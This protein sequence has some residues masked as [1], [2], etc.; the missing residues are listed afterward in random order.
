VRTVLFGS[1]VRVMLTVVAPVSRLGAANPMLAG[2]SRGALENEKGRE[3]DVC[4]CVV[5]PRL[6]VA[7][8]RS[9][10]NEKA[11]GP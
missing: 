2:P 6:R 9:R 7:A 8:P 10:G 5:G 11:A 3:P 4:P 1:G